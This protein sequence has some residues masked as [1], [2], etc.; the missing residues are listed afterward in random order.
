MDQ[1]YINGNLPTVS[2]KFEP[3]KGVT[4]TEGFCNMTNRILRDQ[5]SCF[6]QR[7]GQVCHGT[8]TPAIR[9]ACHAMHCTPLHAQIERHFFNHSFFSRDLGMS[10]AS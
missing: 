4:L 2:E 7:K 10:M 1:D 9:H 5:R 6:V 8:F 3:P